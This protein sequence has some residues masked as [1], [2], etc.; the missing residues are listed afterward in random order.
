MRSEDNGGWK[1]TV[2]W[3]KAFAD[4]PSYSK[5]ETLKKILK[6]QKT[7]ALSW[8]KPKNGWL[9]TTRHIRACSFWVGLPRMNAELELN[10]RRKQP[11]ICQQEMYLVTFYL[12]VWMKCHSYS[13]LLKRLP[14]LMPKNIHFSVLFC[15]A[16][17]VY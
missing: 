2:R 10:K 9:C 13:F 15:T 14:Y 4:R 7:C 1:M 6:P 12:F 3:T 11:L 8:S 5:V 16:P 17:P